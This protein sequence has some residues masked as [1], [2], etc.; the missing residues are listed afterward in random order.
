MYLFDH[1]RYSLA[2]NWTTNLPHLE[3]ILRPLIHSCGIEIITF[4]Y[5]LL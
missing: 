2:R 4:M 3:Q 1:L 5:H